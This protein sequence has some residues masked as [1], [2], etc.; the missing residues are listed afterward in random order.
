[1]SCDETLEITISVDPNELGMIRGSTW[2][3][4]DKMAD[5]REQRD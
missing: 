1:M 2:D 5:V 3:Q 4:E